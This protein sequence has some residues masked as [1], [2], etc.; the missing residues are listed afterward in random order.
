[1]LLEKIVRCIEILKSKNKT[2]A[3]AEGASNGAICDAF[4]SFASA[5]SVLL[6]GI[7]AFKDHMK[8][9][10]FGIEYGTLQRHG[11]ESAHVAA[12]MAQNLPEYFDADICI[13]ITGAIEVNRNHEELNPICIHIQFADT[14]IYEELLVDCDKTSIIDQT[15]ARICQHIKHKLSP[16][17]VNELE[18]A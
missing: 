10:F 17:R 7:V 9:Y 8:T 3:F 14:Q 15:L 12:L 4:S 16:Q 11:S 18:M 2:V 1:M 5:D 13:S 6:G